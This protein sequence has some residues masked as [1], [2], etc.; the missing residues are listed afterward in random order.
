M[1]KNEPGMEKGRVLTVSKWIADDM[2]N[3][4]IAEYYQK[5]NIIKK[6]RPKKRVK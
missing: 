4:K 6:R 3:R 2:V 1:L 5:Q